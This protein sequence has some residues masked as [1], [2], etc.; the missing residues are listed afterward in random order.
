[1]LQYGA[2]TLDQLAE[3]QRQKL[4]ESPELLQYFQDTEM[5]VSRVLFHMER[6][7]IHLDADA[8]RALG[9]ELDAELAKLSQTMT[10]EVG[11]EI[12]L[13]SSSQIGEYLAGKLGVPLSKTKTGK[14]A[15]NVNEIS[16]FAEQFPFIKSL[17]IYRELAKL[18]STYIDTL[19]ASVA[20]DGRIHTSYSQVAA[21]TGRLSS[22][23]P[24]LQNIPVSSE[25]G[26]KIKSCF[27]AAKGKT[28]LSF[29]YSQ[30]ELRVLAHLTQEPGLIS[31]F[32]AKQDV[33][34]TTAS[35]LFGVAYDDVTKEQRMISKTINFGVIYGMSAFGMSSQLH[36]PV[37]DAQAF[38]T[39]FYK[40]YP[41][42]RKYYDQYLKQGAINGYVETILG[43]QRYVF[44]KPGQKTIDNS[45]RRV[46][47]NYPV[48]GSAAD[49]MK[50][51][52]INVHAKVVE[53]N[54]DVQ[55]LL[56]V[57]DDLVFEVT[58]DPQVIE[59]MIEQVREIM[60]NVYPLVVP[61]EVDVKVGKKWGEM[62]KVGM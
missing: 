6:T 26:L 9:E 44:E 60:C 28:F 54:P 21:N 1:M 58:D 3:K 32:Q 35:Q 17:L 7:G 13:N 24:N 41:N 37:E 48:Q 33:H 45:M 55:L 57:H 59:Q 15:T 31:A 29:D 39:A 5:A 42:I 43:R 11:Y 51:A 56:Q 4:A 2:T 38:I 14:Y 27:K 30:Q 19:I 61:V 16:Q 12:N 20:E 36:I 62:E 52:M 34:R 18:R 49:L 8:L 22:S 47:I 46:L 53:K 23:N 10:Q 40:T 25:Y 50:K